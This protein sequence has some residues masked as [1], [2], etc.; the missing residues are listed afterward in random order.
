MPDLTK[1]WIKFLSY[2]HRTRNHI[3]EKIWTDGWFKQLI[4]SPSNEPNVGKRTFGHVRPANIQISLR[5]RTVIRI[6]IGHILDS[7][8]RKVSSCG[9]RR[10]WSACADAQADQ[11]LR[12]THK[13]KGTFSDVAAQIEMTDSERKTQT[14]SCN[15]GN[16]I[17]IIRILAQPVGPHM[18]IQVTIL[19]NGCGTF[20]DSEGPD[21]SSKQYRGWSGT[22]LCDVYLG[23]HWSLRPVFPNA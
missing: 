18:I 8:G 21:Q 15:S 17:A 10:L 7:Q 12:R 5:I 11:S 16:K 6:F 20:A 9:Q 23:L 1:Q 14:A 3:I 4:F 19:Q 2:G 13:S 22:V